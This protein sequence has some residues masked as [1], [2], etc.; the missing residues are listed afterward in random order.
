MMHGVD[1]R[2]SHVDSDRSQG[3]A[4]LLARSVD[5]DGGFDAAHGRGQVP[6]RRG[7]P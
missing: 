1:V 3:E 4:V 7:V 5:H 2:V 6:A